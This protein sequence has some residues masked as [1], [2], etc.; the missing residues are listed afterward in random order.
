MPS[1]FKKKIMY[2]GFLVIALG[3]VTFK[4]IE[5]SSSMK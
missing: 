5:W 1:L 2:E 3:A 4:N